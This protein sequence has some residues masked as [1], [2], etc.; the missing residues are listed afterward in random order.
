MSTYP[1]DSS[2]PQPHSARV[3]QIINDFLDRRARGE[4]VDEAGLLAGHAELADEL[5]TCLASLRDLRPTQDPLADLVERG[6]LN[7]SDDSRYVGTLGP[8]QIVS[9]LG[10]GGM[11]VVLKAYEE[12]LNRTVALKIL[13]LELAGDSVA[14]S[15]FVHEAR[16]AAG[17]QHPNVVTIYAVGQER[18]VTYLAMEYVDGP[19]L[20]TL[21]RQAGPLPTELIRAIF[22]QLLSG[23]A[24]AHEC[25]L[26]HRDVKAAN[27]LLESCQPSAI[28]S[29]PEES[30]PVVGAE[31]KSLAESS[32][33]RAD[34]FR[35]K[36][37]DFGLARV[38]T[39]QTTLTLPNAFL[40]TPEYMSPEQAR[41]DAQI[42]QRTDL[43]S[44][45]VVLYEMLTGR[46]P[47][48]ADSATATLHRILHDDPPHPH[49]L[50]KRADP[51]LTSLALRLL[52]KR[53]EDRFA[54]ATEVLRILDAHR[55]VRVRTYRRRARRGALLA[56]MGA[57][58]LGLAGWGV[59]QYLLVPPR[60]TNVNIVGP[61]RRTV[62]ILYSNGTRL[63][64][65]P[66]DPNREIRL[67]TAAVAEIDDRR[68][69]A[70]V[71]GAIEPPLDEHNSVLAALDRTG[72][73]L[74]RIPLHSELRQW[75]DCDASPLPCWGVYT[76]L[77][78]DFLDETP[79][80]ELIVCAHNVYDYPQRISLIRPRDGGV[81][82]TFWHFGHVEEI[83][84]LPDFF[85][86]GRPGIVA[87]A[88][89]NK[90][91]GFG[92]ED[93]DDAGRGLR[94]AELRFAH[95]HQVLAVMILDPANMHG[96]GPPPADPSRW[97][98]GGPPGPEVLP[99][100]YAFL[101]LPMNATAKRIPWLAG[102]D[103]RPAPHYVEPDFDAAI[104][105]VKYLGSAS[106]KRAE[107]FEVC[108]GGTSD[109]V[110]YPRLIVDGNLNLLRAGSVP[111]HEPQRGKDAGFWRPYWRPIIQNGRYVDE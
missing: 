34:C 13:R 48:K 41:G 100:A 21:I 110:T 55:R 95:W 101:D 38:L 3:G 89:A 78:A 66:F 96:I 43:Y 23:L 35:V 84:I 99:Y 50:V 14:R 74:W 83:R 28:S 20:A 94:G 15:R 92:R 54:S 111:H 109:S 72:R 79:G 6:V 25:R 56:V 67:S 11:G 68:S 102:P 57:V 2:R 29:Q 97:S 27:I 91:D 42:D 22:Q 104:Q 85:S 4:P 17:L 88:F 63:L 90:L 9:L 16:A 103:G 81:L 106:D 8:Y 60:I 5:R 12:S 69:Q 31:S 61:A 87:W 44:A 30:R 36:L 40:G 107:Q 51:V 98:S 7:R 71:V 10:R 75:P 45:G 32:E 26:I 49:K 73:E 39:G 80:Q 59:R 18:D 24:A 53:P 93:R 58:V 37:A 47:F 82:S 77:S 86:P 64:A 19:S 52:A 62:E 33:L 76:I 46:T 108:L 65:D 1:A 70:V 105:W